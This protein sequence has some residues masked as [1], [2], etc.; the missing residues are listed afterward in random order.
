MHMYEAEEVQFRLLDK[1]FFALQKERIDAGI[2]I[3]FHKG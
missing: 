2:I 1:A 3:G